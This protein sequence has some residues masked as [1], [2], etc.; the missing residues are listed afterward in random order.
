MI[1]LI[2]IFSADLTSMMMGSSRLPFKNYLF[3]SLLGMM[4]SMM[5]ITF[6][7]ANVTNPRSPEFLLS[8]V[9]TVLLTVFSFILYRWFIKQNQKKQANRATTETEE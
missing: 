2:G 3:G 7:G 8:V 6:L 9:L 1:R 5:I 4:P